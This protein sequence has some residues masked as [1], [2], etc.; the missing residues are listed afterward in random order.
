MTVSEH[1]AILAEI[2]IDLEVSLGRKVMSLS[3]I[4][5]LTPGSVIRLTRSAGENIDVVAGGALLG[6]GE[7]VIIEETMGVRITDFCSER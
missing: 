4:L 1:I 6:Y 2:E 3:E 5:D 7:I